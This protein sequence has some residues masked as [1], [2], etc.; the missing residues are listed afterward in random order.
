[1]A[2][3]D[4]ITG[5]AKEVAGKATGDEELAQEGKADQLKAKFQDAVE[6]VK[7]TVGGIADKVKDKLGK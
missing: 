7:D 2:L 4:K 6:D 5:K 3:D 1:M